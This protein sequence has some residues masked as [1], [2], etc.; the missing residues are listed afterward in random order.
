MNVPTDG[1]GRGMARTR[2][3]VVVILAAASLG[4]WWLGRS[5]RGAQSKS[6]FVVKAVDGDTI[7]VRI[8]NQ[9][10]IVRLLGIDTPDRCRDHLVPSLRLPERSRPTARAANK[11]S[12]VPVPLL[13]G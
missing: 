13:Y 10:D 12:C 9:T 11:G 6:A 7:D 5:D 1:Y 2:A 8:G 4:G 3:V